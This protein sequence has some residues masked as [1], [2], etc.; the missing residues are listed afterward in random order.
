M[1]E[2]I[3]PQASSPLD[4][5]QRQ[6]ITD[7]IVLLI[8]ASKKIQGTSGFS[9]EVGNKDYGDLLLIESAKLL[10]QAQALVREVWAS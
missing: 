2:T 4:P 8:E 7:T 10:D 6:L 9:Y 5:A 3:K 1:Q